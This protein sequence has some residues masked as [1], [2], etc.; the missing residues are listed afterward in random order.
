MSMLPMIMFMLLPNKT[1]GTYSG[2]N[3]YMPHT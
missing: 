2:K 1:I 3:K